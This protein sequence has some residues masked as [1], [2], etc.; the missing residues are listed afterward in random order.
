[1]KSVF[2][3]LLLS[4]MALMGLSIALAKEPDPFDATIRI[5]MHE[6]MQEI[7]EEE[8]ARAANKGGTNPRRGFGL[9]LSYW[10]GSYG[11]ESNLNV[12]DHLPPSPP[13]I[14]DGSVA[15]PAQTG[16]PRQPGAEDVAI[17]ET[18]ARVRPGRTPSPLPAIPTFTLERA[19]QLALRDNLSLKAQ[20]YQVKHKAALEAASFLDM[21]PDLALSSSRSDTLSDHD[22][23]ASYSTTLTVSQPIYHGKTL[24]NAWEKAK[25]GHTQATLD[26]VREAQTL[27]RQVKE[28][29]YGLLEANYLAK[30]AGSALRRLHQ[31]AKHA[32]AFYD[33]G[34]YWANDVLQAQVEI[35][36]GEQSL[37]EA[38]NDL[39]LAKAN[40]NKLMQRPINAA[41]PFQGALTWQPLDWTIEEAFRSALENRKDLKK[42]QLEMLA[43]KL[44]EESKNADLQPQVDLRGTRQWS[45]EDI[46]YE[47]AQPETKVT[48]S[49]SWKAWEWG[50]TLREKAAAKASTQ[51]SYLKLK[52]LEGSIQ[53]EVR[54]AYL[55]AEEYSRKVA[56]LKKSLNQAKENYRV[57]QIRYQEKLGTAT[58]VLDAMDLLTTTRNSHISAV[59]RYLKS[60]ASLDHAIGRN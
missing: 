56:V 59:S 30:E 44:S 48:V 58:D 4:G 14:P 9:L 45:S 43:N 40:L 55:E 36:Q 33:E 2:V 23:G 29:W 53:L 49:M 37:I 31:H 5:I 22:N 12:S 16:G 46:S 19:L 39:F 11:Q 25:I 32:K 6:S 57:N 7:E 10:F 26:E 18:T 20:H 24:W 21:L 13:G 35:A 42:S 8:R 54:K 17:V 27:V 47:G 1:M 41:L 60:L 15:K 34:S 52:D 3:S 28:A 51:K 50:K 38:N